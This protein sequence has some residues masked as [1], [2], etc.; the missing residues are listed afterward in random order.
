MTKN[1]RIKY[2]CSVFLVGVLRRFVIIHQVFHGIS[3]RV[4]RKKHSPLVFC[5]GF[6]KTGT[7]SL[8]KAL[9]ILGYRHVHWPRAHFEPYQGWMEYIRKCPFDA[10]SDAP[11]YYPGFFKQLDYAFPGSKFIFTV[12]KPE[13]FMRSWEN[14]FYYAPWSL[15]MPEKKDALLKAYTNHTQEVL[16]YFRDKPSQLLVFDIIGGDG[17]EKLCAFLDQPIPAIAF[18]HKRNAKYKK[19]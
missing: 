8:D 13:S 1:K 10:F 5:I 16:E 7:T 18:P 14:Y 11:M 6:S 2:W 9:A 17:W 12:R 3:V 15:D 19:I 4:T